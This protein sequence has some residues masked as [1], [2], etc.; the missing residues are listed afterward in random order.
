MKKNL[1]IVL[2]FLS[3]GLCAQQDTLKVISYNIWNGFDFRKDVERQ[4]KVINW[5]VANKPDVVALQ[6]L[7]GYTEEKLLEDAKRWGHNYAILLKKE[8]HSV[9]LTSVKPIVL[10]E[11]VREDF[12]HGMLHCETFGV[13]FFVVHM[14]PKDRDFRIK[15][16]KIILSRIA[17][18]SNNYF[19]VLG[20]FN[21]QSPFDGDRDIDYPVALENIRMGDFKNAKYNNLLDYEFDYSVMSSFIASPL[22]D[23]IQRFVKPEERFTFP[24]KLRSGPGLSDKDKRRIDFIMVSRELAKKCS[25]SVVYNKEE[26]ALLSDH[27]PV[28]AEFELDFK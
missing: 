18:I 7:C 24:T 25:N 9:G 26:T 27:Y 13:D 22:I 8:C 20:D 2:C 28:M 11:K 6:E 16:S 3:T 21:A 14:S 5:F 10:K 23:V 19:M 1:I 4:N 12:W 15:E 17:S